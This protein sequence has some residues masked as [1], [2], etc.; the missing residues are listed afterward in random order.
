MYRTRPSFFIS[1]RTASCVASA[2]GRHHDQVDL[3]HLERRELRLDLRFHGGGVE[4][5]A[6]GRRARPA[7]ADGHGRRPE[8]LVLNPELVGS[9]AGGLLPRRPAVQHVDDSAAVVEQRLEDLLERGVIRCGRAAE[10]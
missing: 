7:G 10:S 8:E 1:F 9:R 5:A 2:R 6:A 4:L 3:G